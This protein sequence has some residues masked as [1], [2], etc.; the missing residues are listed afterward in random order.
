LEEHVTQALNI[1]LVQ[2]RCEKG[3][4]DE[5]LAAIQAS[6]QEAGSRG[7]DIICF[8]EMSITG[9]IDPTQRP[10]AVLRVDSPEAARFARLTEGTRVT[11]LAGIDCS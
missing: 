11:A 9:Y 3:A 6:I 4:I 2:M 10:E 8:P 1:A 5:N 7:V